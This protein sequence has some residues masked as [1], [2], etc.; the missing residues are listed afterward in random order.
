MDNKIKQ[1]FIEFYF[2]KG[3]RWFFRIF[4]ILFLLTIVMYVGL[5]W[6]INSNK[7]EVQASL[8][9]QLNGGL[10]GSLTLEEMDPTFLK[11]FPNISL[12][13]EKVV[14]KDSHINIHNHI[15][16]KAGEL[17]VTINTM[18]LL[19]GT[20]AIRKI[21]INNAV[22]DMFTDKQG[23][24]NTN[25]FKKDK[26]D[27]ND[28]EAGSFPE[29]KNI[30]LEN[31]TLIIDNRQKNKLYK[32]RV[33]SLDGHIKYLSS[34][35][36]ADAKL[37]ALAYSLAFNTQ[38][39]S[40]IKNKTL[41][42]KFEAIFNEEHHSLVVKPNNL[43]IGGDDFVI[44][45]KFYFYNEV[46]KFTINIANESILW[47][48]AARLLSPNITV[49]LGMFNLSKPIKVK[50]DLVGDFNAEG[51]PLILVNA[52]IKDNELETPGGLVSSCS[53]NGV[54]TNNYIK[55]KGLS[56][57]NSAIKLNN[58]KGLYAGLPVAMQKVYIL[59]LDKP[60]AV[61]DFSSQFEMPKLKS[62]I[63]D[64]LLAFSSGTAN[65]KVDF[66]ADIV[67]YKITRPYIKGKIDIEDADITYMPRKMTFKDVSVLLNFTSEDL[68][69]STIALK[70]KHS[71][72]NMDGHI[73]NF[74][75]LYY[76]DPEKIVLNWN[77]NSSQLNVGEFMQFL[78]SRKT[79]KAAIQKNRK[80]NFT[81]EMN[82]FFAKTNVDIHLNVNKLYYKK[83]LATNVRANVLMTDSGVLLK[84]AGLS[85]AGGALT[86]S[87]SMNENG[88][89]NKYK[90]N[91]MVKNVDIGKFFYAFN[92]FG[93]ESLQSDN[94]KG[95]VSAKADISG[96]IT[97]EGELVSKS[98]YGNLSFQL[99][100]GKLLNFDPVRNVGKFV[101]PFR[102]MN[103]IEF[104]NL[105]GDF[106]VAGE[107]ITI[108]PMQINSSVL[109]M[110]LQGVYSFGA[111]TQLY[112][113][114]PL[115]NPKK[116]EDITD[117]KELAKRRNR[118][119][120]VHLTAEDDKDGKVKV[121]LGG[122]KE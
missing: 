79:T 95:R 112:V 37:N 97:D 28:N 111:G 16:L 83:F 81:K 62:I 47:S 53:F 8:L 64:D 78:G 15:L 50:C 74:M 4:L 73:K 71:T 6:Y 102:D 29:L 109:N 3:M 107:K 68:T 49:K 98:M 110:D 76:T 54:F 31:V 1:F 82:D 96:S 108:A 22:I 69:I 56:D 20:I 86:V 119:I 11:G 80:G 9:K 91:A 87:G 21:A 65:V 27:K 25:I 32:F 45:G 33:N 59:N 90:V 7:N 58:F 70:T 92:N 19:R 30:L 93:M 44:G 41:K 66:R 77:V 55:S 26:T 105:K 2:S 12:R 104:D 63:D 75:N 103:T 43:E 120:V 122:K 60:V 72:I 10:S 100:H 88:R 85:H 121:K 13:L 35:I 40:F 114:V 38:R 89:Y 5:A 14:L 36:K 39:G 67:D 46:A 106:A 94:L 118:G 99:K 57:E 51:D 48:N 101:F 34:G 113:D 52:E 116:D 84:N 24:S 117:K 23:Y 42:G 115:R 61:G 18:A 17:D